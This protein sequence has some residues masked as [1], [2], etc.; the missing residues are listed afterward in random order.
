V[1]ARR[2]RVRRSSRA[3][4]GDLVWV[5]TIIQASLLESTPTDIGLLVIPADWSSAGGGFDR[6]TLMGIRGWLSMVQQG[7]ATAAEATGCYTALYVTDQAVAANSMDP[8]TATEYSDF[9]TLWTDGMA[10]TAAASTAQ[11]AIWSR[12]LEV[13]TRRKLTSAS[14][15]R[16]AGAVDADSATPRVNW[17]GVVRTLLKLDSSR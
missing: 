13:K 16:L 2:G 4:N 6:C 11:Q 8:S 15:V 12:Q 1:A 7:A 9:D 5:T 3:K 10:L 17:V 14:S